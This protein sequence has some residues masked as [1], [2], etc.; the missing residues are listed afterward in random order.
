MMIETLFS[1]SP[2]LCWAKG[3]EWNCAA[4]SPQH[5]RPHSLR[6]SRLSCEPTSFPML[7]CQGGPEPGSTLSSCLKKAQAGP[8]LAQHHSPRETCWSEAAVVTLALSL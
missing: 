4:A 1:R 5:L 7:S 3:R 6:G 2:G 8:A